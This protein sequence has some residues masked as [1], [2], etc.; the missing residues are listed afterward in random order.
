VKNIV[1]VTILTTTIE[2]LQNL[3][4]IDEIVH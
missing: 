4:S 3:G 2:Y 1:C